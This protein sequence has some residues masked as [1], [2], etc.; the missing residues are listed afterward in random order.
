MG[1]VLLTSSDA[2]LC[3]V[4]IWNILIHISWH[5]LLALATSS[6]VWSILAFIVV[7]DA[8]HSLSHDS[9]VGFSLWASCC[10]ECI[11]FL[12]CIQSYLLPMTIHCFFPMLGS[13]P[14]FWCHFF[15]FLS[16]SLTCLLWLSSSTSLLLPWFFSSIVLL[17][18][19]GHPCC[20]L[21][22]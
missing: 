6:F 21:L 9:L 20:L 17:W 7:L 8:P 1:V 4:N 12:S 5:L 22:C 3:F 14:I 13:L 19:S 11:F 18:T 10:L 15:W 2:G 16:I